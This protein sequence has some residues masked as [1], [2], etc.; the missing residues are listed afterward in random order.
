MFGYNKLCYSKFLVQVILLR[1]AKEYFFPEN[2]RKYKELVKINTQNTI[3]LWLLSFKQEFYVSIFA[4]WLRVLLLLIE[5]KSKTRT[6]Y[7]IAQ[8]ILLFDFSSN[9]IPFSN[10]IT[11][12]IQ[13]N[14]IDYLKVFF[15]F[16]AIEIEFEC[17]CSRGMFCFARNFFI[18]LFIL[19]KL[20]SDSFHTQSIYFSIKTINK[21]IVFILLCIYNYLSISVTQI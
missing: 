19:A 4:S 10:W 9:E 18:Q 11:V 6:Y 3:H 1:R 12:A 5:L 16:A 8:F 7:L 17:S 15:F 13:T 20:D 2:E 14:G 21:N